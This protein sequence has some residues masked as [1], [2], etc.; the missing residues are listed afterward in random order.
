MDVPSGGTYSEA[1]KPLPDTLC[2]RNEPKFTTGSLSHMT[3]PDIEEAF[4][5]LSTPLQGGFW[6]NTNIA[7]PRS[8]Y[9]SV[10]SS[11]SGL[12]TPATT[13]LPPSS[14]AAPMPDWCQLPNSLSL[15]QMIQQLTSYR[16]QMA[17]VQGSDFPATQSWEEGFVAEQ[18]VRGDMAWK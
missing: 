14:T 2:S 11:T 16:V 8:D 3:L 13:P 17:E 7:S 1:T 18:G 5:E 12:A 6:A 4:C 15:D 9:H 10:I